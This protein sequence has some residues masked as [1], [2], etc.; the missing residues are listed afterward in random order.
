MS[1]KDECKDILTR[2]N[3]NT[4]R[5]EAGKIR[6]EGLGKGLWLYRGMSYQK[7]DLRR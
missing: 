5:R 4:R 2:I 1:D 3:E 6:K 7:E